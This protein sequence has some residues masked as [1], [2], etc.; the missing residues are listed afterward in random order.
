V[1]NH[2]YKSV[3]PSPSIPSHA[4]YHTRESINIADTEKPAFQL[5]FLGFTLFDLSIHFLSLSYFSA[6]VLL[7]RQV[8]QNSLLA[9]RLG[10]LPQIG[11]NLPESQRRQVAA[12]EKAIFLFPIHS[13][14]PH[15]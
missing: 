14:S 8:K 5:L 1:V 12:E 6:L 10:F 2:N 9:K 4:T 15:S 13:L 3:L 11:S 7:W